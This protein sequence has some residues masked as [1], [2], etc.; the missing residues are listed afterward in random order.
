MDYNLAK[1]LIC[2]DW[3]D[4]EWY[5]N[6]SQPTSQRGVLVGFG[7]RI[8][9]AVPIRSSSKSPIRVNPSYSLNKSAPLFFSSIH[10]QSLPTDLFSPRAD[11]WP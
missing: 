5:S 4:K 10:T 1:H 7:S 6:H 9:G 11:L 3:D 2:I 8:E